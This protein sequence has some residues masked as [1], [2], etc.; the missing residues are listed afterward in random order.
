[1]GDVGFMK[2]DIMMLREDIERIERKLDIIIRYL[3]HLKEE[4]E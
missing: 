2:I 1:L 4:E 3:H